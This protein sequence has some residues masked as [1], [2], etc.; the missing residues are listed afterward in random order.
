MLTQGGRMEIFMDKQFKIDARYDMCLV[1]YS[2]VREE[3][4][5]EIRCQVFNQGEDGE[6]TLDFYLDDEKLKSV[7]VFVKSKEYGFANCFIDMRGRAGEH[8]VSVNGASCELT[9][10]KDNKALL[11]GGFIMIGPP[12]NRKSCGIFRADLKN[13]S[14]E[15]WEEYID[16]MSDMGQSCII[17]MASH[18]YINLVYENGKL[19]D[20]IVAHYPSKIYKKSDIV[21]EDPIAAILRAAERNGQ[22][23]F[24]AV[25]NGYGHYGTM[26]ELSELYDRYKKYVSF[27]GWYFACELNLSRTLTIDRF[28]KFKD[29][30]EIA[31]KISPV[32]PILMSPM[33]IPCKEVLDY[34]E[35]NDIYDIIMPQDWVGQ[36]AHT[37]EQSDTM[38]SLLYESCK[39]TNKHLWANCESFNFS[40]DYTN[41]DGINLLVPRFKDGG[42]DGEAGFIQQMQTVRPYVEKIMNFMFTGFFAPIGF[43]PKVGGDKAVK[44]YMDYVDY[45][46]R[47]NKQ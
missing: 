26:D 20:D 43:E 35:E 15:K 6:V 5:L 39:K 37:L 32:K 22:K 21:S 34:I 17:I 16:A 2:P 13:F 14:E 44:Q 29:L 46:K 25:G 24:I 8:T 12:N 27:Y 30:T 7:T 19:V 28:E 1:P 23:V 41:D 3:D 42:M 18:Q 33:A 38:H 40:E 10:I 45:V 47:I 36:K 11:D 9:V 31:R 4:T